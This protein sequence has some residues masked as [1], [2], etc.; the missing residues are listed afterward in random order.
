MNRSIM[1]LAS[2]DFFREE[3]VCEILGVKKITMQRRRCV[4]QGHPPFRKLG[5]TVLYPK[6]E[7][8]EWLDTVAPIKREISGR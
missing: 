8:W 5:A 6:K 7:F 4:G 1:Q 2:P 3:E